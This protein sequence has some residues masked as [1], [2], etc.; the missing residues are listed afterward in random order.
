[1]NQF[2]I[3][4][5]QYLHNR[6]I[7]ILVKFSQTISQETLEHIQGIS[8]LLLT[9]L[10]LSPFSYLIV[11][12]EIA[13]IILGM[14]IKEHRKMAVPWALG[15][16][17]FLQTVFSEHFVIVFA[18]LHVYEICGVLLFII[19]FPPITAFGKKDICL[20]KVLVP[21]LTPECCR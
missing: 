2:N 15:I 9:L 21:S 3:R 10:S 12:D 8:P 13:T 14:K 4:F 18:F 7:Q 5:I 19:F 11:A 20:H 17:C 6:R 16:L 1:M